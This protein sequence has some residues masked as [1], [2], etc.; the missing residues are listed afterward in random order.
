MF[1]PAIIL[2]STLS[3]IATAAAATETTC[4]DLGVENA[5][6]ADHFCAQLQA[7]VPQ[8]GDATG[9][10]RSITQEG[11]PDLPDDQNW[12]NFPLIEDAYRADPRKTLELIARIKGAGGLATESN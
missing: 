3:L 4:P 8:D 10:T 9:I 7:I 5:F 12:A 2:C 1:R 6:L 11:N